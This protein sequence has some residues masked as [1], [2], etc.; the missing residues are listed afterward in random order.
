MA[1]LNGG[2]CAGKCSQRFSKHMQYGS[3]GLSPLHVRVFD[4][5]TLHSEHDSPNLSK[6][7]R[8]SGDF[9][10]HTFCIVACQFL[11]LVV[12]G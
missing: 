5:E 8:D 2:Q 1:C 3:S 9:G 6:F 12:F 4:E 11:Q 10:L 7:M